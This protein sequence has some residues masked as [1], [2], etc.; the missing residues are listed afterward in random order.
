MRFIAFAIVILLASG[1]ALACDD[2]VGNCE[3]EDWNYSY[4][5]MM[6][7]LT[8]DGVATCDSGEVRLRLYDGEGEGRKFLAVDIA[9][10]APLKILLFRASSI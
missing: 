7:A 4:T 1:G 8:I 9:Y 10:R 3:I 6:K 2:H 5:P